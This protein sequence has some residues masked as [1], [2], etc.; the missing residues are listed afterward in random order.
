MRELEWSYNEPFPFG[1][2]CAIC[3]PV[4]RVFCSLARLDDIP[5]LAE[6]QLSP[7]NPAIEG[8]KPTRRKAKQKV[9][10]DVDHGRKK[11]RTDQEIRPE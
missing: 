5:A 10:D 3:A 4:R 8:D 1:L 7:L 2:K 6:W 11:I 9:F